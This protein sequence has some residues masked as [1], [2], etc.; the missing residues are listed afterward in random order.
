MGGSSGLDIEKFV[1][2]FFSVRR[3]PVL[4]GGCRSLRRRQHKHP[5]TL[6]PD[7]RRGDGGDVRPADGRK[8]GAAFHAFALSLSKGSRDVDRL[9]PDRCDGLD[10]Y[11]EGKYQSRSCRQESLALNM[12]FRGETTG[13][14]AALHPFALSLSKG[15]R[16]ADRLLP[17]RCDGLDANRDGKYQS[18]PCRQEFLALSRGSQRT[19]KRE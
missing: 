1:T 8:A 17:D 7:V 2:R 13:S 11:G 6:G 4:T 12:E 10:A 3:A 14:S 5:I 16:D 19:G 15:S 9:L 18:P